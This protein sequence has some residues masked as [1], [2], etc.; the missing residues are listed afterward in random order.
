MKRNRKW[1][2][3]AKQPYM[4]CVAFLVRL[5]NMCGL[6]YKQISVVLNLWIQG[7]VLLLTGW[8]PFIIAL[9]RLPGNPSYKDYSLIAVLALYGI[10]YLMGFVWM[11]RHYRLPFNRAFSICVSDL[12]ILAAKWGVTYQVVNLFILVFL[13]LAIII[14]NFFMGYLAITL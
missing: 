8:T 13:F 2:D 14:I 1:T 12:Q 5:G 6:T 7:G 4:M 3:W 10:I 9:W 11:L